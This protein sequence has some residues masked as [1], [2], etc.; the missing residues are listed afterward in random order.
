MKQMMRSHYHG[1]KPMSED[2]SQP[3]TGSGNE[4]RN[5]PVLSLENIVVQFQVAQSGLGDL[6]AEPDTVQA[7]DDVSIDI[8]ENDVLVIV[9]ESGCGKTTLGKTAIGLQRPTS[10]SVKY[11]GQEIWD[12]KDRVGEVQIPYDEIRQSLQYIHQD[13]GSSLNPNRKV[14]SSLL[15]PLN[16]IHPDL[17]AAEK[18][19]RVLTMLEYVGMSPP[20]DYADRY[21]H[22]LSGGEQQRIA[23]IRA[24]LMD[25]DLILADEAVS[26]LDVSLRIEI[27]DLMLELQDIWGTSFIFI[28]HNLSNARYL[29]EN[30]DGRVAIMYL[31]DIVEIGDI[32]D[33]LDN[34]IHPYTDALKW[35][36]PEVIPSEDEPENP[37]EG[38]DIPDPVNLPSGCR[39]HTR[40]PKAREV[41]KS[42]EPKSYD[43]DGHDDQYSACFRAVDD[44]PYWNSEPLDHNNS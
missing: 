39:F 23:I 26:A 22:Q 24:F 13:P 36:S 27:M 21:P 3:R 17:S 10:G 44:H 6:F 12:A 7:V 25:P 28:S 33:I 37:I 5:E 15:E 31:G 2:M 42:E 30:S 19:D 9:G 4:G 34:S 14:I 40:C 18:R 29:A 43:I 8:S 1:G 16:N 35:A 38:I 11:R 32:Y 20:T 41:C